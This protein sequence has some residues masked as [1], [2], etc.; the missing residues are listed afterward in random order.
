MPL[1]P[2]ARPVSCAVPFARSRPLP[3][4]HRHRHR[5][6][7][8]V[9]PAS[10]D[11]SPTV[12][13]TEG[14]KKGRT[15]EMILSTDLA[16]DPDPCTRGRTSP[17]LQSARRDEDEKRRDETRRRDAPATVGEVVFLVFSLLSTAAEA[18]AAALS[19][20]DQ[21]LSGGK[22]GDEHGAISRLQEQEQDREQRE[23]VRPRNQSSVSLCPPTPGSAE[24]AK[25]PAINAI[26]EHDRWSIWTTTS[27][28][29][30]K[31]P[32][33]CSLSIQSCVA[34][35]DD[36]DPTLDVLLAS[37]SLALQS[38]QKTLQATLT[39]RTHLARLR[40]DEY[41]LELLMRRREVELLTQLEATRQMA[42]YVEERTSE[43][44]SLLRSTTAGSSC[45]A[46][47]RNPS[48]SSS[49]GGWGIGAAMG[50]LAA[51]KGIPLKLTSIEKEESVTGIL[52]APH[53]EGVTIGKSAARRLERMLGR[54]A[55]SSPR[56]GSTNGGT[57]ANYA[58]SPPRGKMDARDLLA[59]PGASTSEASF[60]DGLRSSTN[61]TSGF[62]FFTDPYSP[63]RAD[64]SS[65]LWMRSSSGVST[66]TAA[67]FTTAKS[68][69]TLAEPDT[70]EEQIEEL[71]DDGDSSS[72]RALSPPISPSLSSSTSFC[73]PGPSRHSNYF[74]GATTKASCPTTPST[75][76][77][78]S[79]SPESAAPNRRQRMHRSH[80]SA[81]AVVSVSS[82]TTASSSIWSPGCFT[83]GDWNTADPFMSDLP[84]GGAA[85][86]AATSA[87]ASASAIVSLRRPGHSQRRS[88]SATSVLSV[89][90]QG[91][92]GRIA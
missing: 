70:T 68:I 85:A 45:G 55:G 34:E 18:A 76:P 73:S 3:I 44:Q 42:E 41:A 78:K 4:G 84:G 75:L 23:G 20:L 80:P 9:F 62:G 91:Q 32:E 52:E 26:N 54:A 25:G 72:V 86:S 65:Y 31:E 33:D 29:H 57:S 24:D 69:S 7:V 22:G 13:R 66:V 43:L 16:P 6:G 48:Y 92:S 51:G 50:D 15:E 90:G 83:I 77:S 14:G 58:R 71:V 8:F 21:D 79:N 38:A 5:R 35:D 27:T 59:S 12:R 56:D 37:S 49:R 30:S 40:A 82:T 87:V 28:L 46:P 39:P 1:F 11:R 88:A 17:P 19:M 47:R 64:K 60:G 63:R 89:A 81:P 74:S 67:S 36:D 61:A 53:H 2:F 10:R